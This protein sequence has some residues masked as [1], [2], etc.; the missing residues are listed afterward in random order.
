MENPFENKASS[1][2]TKNECNHYL[3][4]HEEVIHPNISDTLPCFYGPWSAMTAYQNRLV[5]HRYYS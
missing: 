5:S 1:N 4:P 3:L 2:N